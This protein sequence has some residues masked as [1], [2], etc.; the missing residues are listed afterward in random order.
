[1]FKVATYAVVRRE[2]WLAAASCRLYTLWLTQVRENGLQ[3]I[4]AFVRLAA[5]LCT[6]ALCV[7][8]QWTQWDILNMHSIALLSMVLNLPPPPPL[9][10]FFLNFVMRFLAY[11]L[12]NR[13]KYRA[14]A[15]RLHT[16]CVHIFFWS[17]CKE[18]WSVGVSKGVWI[19]KHTNT[20]VVSYTG[21][22]GIPC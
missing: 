18:M 6:L 20:W 8:P 13:L 15:K 14:V 3:T 9:V 4:D 10:F 17:A 22:A 21:L 1:M 5:I 11:K 16:L 12:A 2:L 7:S 19:Y